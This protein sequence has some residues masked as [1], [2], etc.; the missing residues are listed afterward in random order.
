MSTSASKSK[1]NK[2][3]SL[4]PISAAISARIDRRDAILQFNETA[5]G[6]LGDIQAFEHDLAPLIHQ[7]VSLAAN[8]DTIDLTQDDRRTLVLE[9]ITNVMPIFNNERDRKIVSNLI[10]WIAAAPGMVHKV[11]DAALVSHRCFSFLKKK[12]LA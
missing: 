6:V 9:F 11:S 12:V 2:R 10:D 3:L 7:L 4:V 8:I 1:K 5:H